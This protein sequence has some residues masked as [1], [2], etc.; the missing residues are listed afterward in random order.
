MVSG[1]APASTLCGSA[2]ETVPVALVIISVAGTVA[3]VERRARSRE[4]ALVLTALGGVF[5]KRLIP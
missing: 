3:V 5:F 4:L 1:R 2:V